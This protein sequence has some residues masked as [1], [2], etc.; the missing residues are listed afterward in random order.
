[1]SFIKIISFIIIMEISGQADQTKHCP[2]C[3]IQLHEAQNY[4]SQLEKT[5]KSN[6]DDIA[7]WMK[8]YSDE[9]TSKA[10]YMEKNMTWYMDYIAKYIALEQKVT[11]SNNKK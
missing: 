7:R 5:I 9:I 3:S 8:M 11:A 4:I 1:M 2:T 6:H 10:S